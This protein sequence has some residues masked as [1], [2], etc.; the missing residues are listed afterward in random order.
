MEKNSDIKTESLKKLKGG[1]DIEIMNSVKR[2]SGGL[3]HANFFHI[4]NHVIDEIGWLEGGEKELRQRLERLTLDG[5]LVYLPE[6]ER[7]SE[8]WELSDSGKTIY[9]KSE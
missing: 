4:N 9:E 7:S 2:W 6:T 1:Y 3:S 8:Y 5:L